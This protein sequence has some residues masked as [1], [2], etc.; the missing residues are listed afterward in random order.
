MA[1]TLE[2]KRLYSVFLG[3]IR[4]KIKVNKLALFV[5][6]KEINE[7]LLVDNNGLMD[8]DISFPC[9]EGLLWQNIL[10]SE[11]FQVVDHHG[12]PL[13]QIPHMNRKIS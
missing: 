7:F 1:N 3:I 12:N 11:P 13:S 4:E 8:N 2:P 6:E 9:R 5:F 10:Q